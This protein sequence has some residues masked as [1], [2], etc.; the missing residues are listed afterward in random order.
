LGRVGCEAISW[1]YSLKTAEALADQATQENFDK[2]SIFPPFTNIRKIS[3]HIAAAVAAKAYELGMPPSVSL[4][5]QLQ[6]HYKSF[7]SPP[8]L[9]KLSYAGLATRLPPSRDLVKYAESCMYTP[10]YRNYR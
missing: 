5:R 3:A 10:V 2:G 6:C 4:C 8:N 1:F 9:I 7:H